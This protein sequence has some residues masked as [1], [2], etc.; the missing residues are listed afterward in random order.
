MV[1]VQALVK[2]SFH[3]VSV[4]HLDRYLA[5]LEW[6]FNNRIFMDTLRRTVRT[7]ALPYQDLIAEAC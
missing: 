6:C 4:K 2:G 7:N 3:K 5:E 1:A